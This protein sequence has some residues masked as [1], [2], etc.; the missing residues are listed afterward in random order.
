MTADS[1]QQWKTVLFTQLRERNRRERDHFRSVFDSCER[2]L[3]G[4]LCLT[5]VLQM[6]G[7][8]R[9]LQACEPETFSLSR[10]CSKLGA[11]LLSTLAG[12][13][14]GIVLWFVQPR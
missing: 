12:N 7:S 14:A 11:R 9:H 2:V 5:S 13:P 6:S 3:V 10:K 8:W 1:S 4:V